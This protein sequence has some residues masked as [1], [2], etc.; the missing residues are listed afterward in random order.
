VADWN[1]KEYLKAKIRAAVKNLLIKDINGRAT[2]TEIE[3]L[4][5]DVIGNAETIYLLQ[6]SKASQTNIDLKDPTS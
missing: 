5:S 2:Y 4:S 6:E 3:Q 1:R